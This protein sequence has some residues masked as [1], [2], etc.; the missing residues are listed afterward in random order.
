MRSTLKPR[1]KP[2][3]KRLIL[4]SCLVL[5]MCASAGVILAT[6]K[7][8]AVF[9]ITPKDVADLAP[10]KKAPGKSLRLGGLVEKG[11]VAQGTSGMLAF[12]ITDLTASVPVTYQGI[13]PSLFREE[14][15]VVAEGSFDEN[16]VFVA[17]TLLAKHDENYMPPEVV[18]ALKA[19]GRWQHTENPAP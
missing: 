3:H 15:G 5:F 14:Q 6:F 2:K 1:M 16:G 17:R 18:D 4:V 12:N 10:E 9:F 7:E 11:S 13:I 8:Y 19:S